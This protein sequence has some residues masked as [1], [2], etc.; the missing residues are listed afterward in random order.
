MSLPISDGVTERLA[1]FLNEVGKHLWDSR[2]RA[3][4]A[5]YMLGLL[6]SLPRESVE[7]VSALFVTDPDEAD[8]GINSGSKQ[9]PS[10]SVFYTAV[11]GTRLLR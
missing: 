6:S 1:Q 11:M 9:W 7:A 4:F 5:M 8:A 2:Q 10:A 3:S